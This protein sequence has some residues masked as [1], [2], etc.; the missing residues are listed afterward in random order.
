[1]V[2]VNIIKLYADVFRKHTTEDAERRIIIGTPLT[3]PDIELTPAVMPKPWLFARVLAL[4]IVAFIG[5]YIGVSLYQNPLFLPGMILFGSIITPIS[6]LIFFWEI[7]IFQNISIYKLTLTMVKGSI[8]SLLC[9]VTLFAILDGQNSPLIIGFVEETAKVVTILLVAD[10]RRY[11]YVL[12]GML[13]GAAIGTGFA[14]FESAGYILVTVL[15]YGIPTML[16]TVFWRALFT[17]GGHI[18]WAALTGATLIIVKGDRP[19]KMKML[20][21]PKF[22]GM[23]ALVIVLHALWDYDAIQLVVYNIPVTPVVLTIIS[24]I[25]MFALMKRGFRQAV[26]AA[27]DHETPAI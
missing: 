26:E 27:D 25:I 3:T 13:M 12:N 1:M 17:P 23:F 18:A 9:A 19:F 4:S 22:L 8:V 16:A 6:L 5:F 10:F 14:A 20:L 2:N 24:W 11:K 15:Q 21:D 7:N